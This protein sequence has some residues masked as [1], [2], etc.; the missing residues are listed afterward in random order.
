M[1]ET[2]T[3]DEGDVAL[4][5]GYDV[6]DGGEDRRDGW[7]AINRTRDYVAAILNTINTGFW[8]WARISGKPTTF[9]PSSHSHSSL[10][11]G[12]G[13]SF[14]WNANVAGGAWNTGNDLN[15]NGNFLV[16]NAGPTTS[17][18]VDAYLN[19]DGRLSAGVSSRRFKED[20]QPVG[21]AELDLFAVPL[22][23]F[24]MKD[25]DGARIIGYIAEELEAHPDTQR[26]VIYRDGEVY[27]IDRQQLMMAQIIHLNARLAV[28]EEANE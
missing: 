10:S 25:G 7:R 12:T 13:K 24:Q 9:P 4:A 8:P 2:Y 23:E 26:F 20:I 17:G 28:L 3:G 27:S 5:A 15:V 21:V 1:P 18:P 6:M 22:R 14:G 16:P 11:A 19:S